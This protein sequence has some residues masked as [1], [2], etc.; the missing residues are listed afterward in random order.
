[1]LLAY[2][3][4]SRGTAL[5]LGLAGYY[6]SFVE[7]LAYRSAALH[8][9]ENAYRGVPQTV[10]HWVDVHQAQFNRLKYALSSAPVLS[11]LDPQREF[12]L[13][14]DV[15]DFVIGTVLA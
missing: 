11:M 4:V 15:L 7:R 3:D 1:L 2:A 9:L 8:D 10:F 13:R 14:T 5:M 6:C 12:S